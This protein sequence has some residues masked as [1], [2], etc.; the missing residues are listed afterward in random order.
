MTLFLIPKLEGFYKKD[1]INI[2]VQL[3][4]RFE[5]RDNFDLDS[6]RDDKL[7]FHLLRTRININYSPSDFLK[8]FIQLQ[9]SRL[10]EFDPEDPSKSKPLRVSEDP[11]ISKD[12]TGVADP[13]EFFY[14]QT[15][16]N[17]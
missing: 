14:F 6:Q 17:F 1:L 3:R 15:I 12:E 11:S 13:G 7:L 16:L 10:F 5:A 8:F 4:H 2:S 9:D